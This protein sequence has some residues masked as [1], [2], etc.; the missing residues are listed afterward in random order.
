L[1]YFLFWKDIFNFLS[2]KKKDF[3]KD[4]NRDGYLLVV[5][6]DNFSVLEG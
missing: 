5:V 1:G 4:K 6:K 3:R 2:P